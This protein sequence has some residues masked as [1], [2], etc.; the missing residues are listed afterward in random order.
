MDAREDEQKERRRRKRVLAM[1]K[2]FEI[3]TGEYVRITLIKNL[4]QSIEH[5][6]T[7]KVI[8]SPKEI[9]GYLTDECDDFYYLGLEPP[10]IHIA[11]NKKEVS[12]FEF[13]D[14]S[15]AK[16]DILKDFMDSPEKSGGMN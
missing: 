8:E 4:K 15:G 6:G 11:V 5:G 1:S 14:P 3:F 16:D 2:I 7:L 13:T 10:H 9:E 12:T